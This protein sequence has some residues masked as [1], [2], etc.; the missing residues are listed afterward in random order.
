MLVPACDIGFVQNVLLS[1]LLE[2]KV[3]GYFPKEI[4]LKEEY[5]FV[6]NAV[7]TDPDDQSGWFYHLWLLDQTVNVD[8]PILVSSWPP[9]GSEINKTTFPIVLCF[10][11]PVEGVTLHTVSLQIENDLFTNV[12][13]SPL[14]TNKFNHGQTWL[15]HLTIP[16]AELYSSKIFQ[17]KISSESS[18]GVISLSGVPCRPWSF[19][20]TVSV[21]HDLQN[22]EERSLRRISFT[23]ENFAKFDVN[24]NVT[25]LLKSYFEVTGNYEQ[26]APSKWKSEMIS[27]EIEQYQELLTSAE[28]Y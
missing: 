10:N 13:W 11:E 19:T 6:R 2:K 12:T 9:H 15:T 17:V 1:H 18:Q 27:S 3:E 20:F 23:D 14:S 5:E 7:F 22:V 25:D 16:Q 24:S 28:W 21:S 26:P 8:T 4:F